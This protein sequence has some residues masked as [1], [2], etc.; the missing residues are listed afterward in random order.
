[1][2]VICV[3]DREPENIAKDLGKLPGMKVIVSRMET[4]DILYPMGQMVIERKT[5]SDLLGSIASDRVFDQVSRMVEM[6]GI[7][8][9]I[10]MVVGTFGVNKAGKVI[11]DK[12]TTGWS[13]WSIQM[14]LMSLQARGAMVIQTDD[15]VQC[16]KEL[17]AWTEKRAKQD[18]VVTHTKSIREAPPEVAFLS[19][20][21]GIGP[22]TATNLLTYTG[23]VGWALAA[24]T[25]KRTAADVPGVGPV[26]IKKT[27]EFFGLDDGSTLTVLY[28]D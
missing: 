3:D 10:V 7:K 19:G 28:E 14:A 17:C 5:V 11:A 20:L 24:L 25:Q 2:N 27:R 22:V 26:T 8:F 23:S 9:P 6:P 18:M 21:P 13:P 16:V 4:G 1:M 12:R 15:W